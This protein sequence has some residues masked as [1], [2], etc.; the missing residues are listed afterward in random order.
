[1]LRPE[2]APH[3]VPWDTIVHDAK[4][5]D[6]RLT[7]SLRARPSSDTIVV[8]VHG[9]GGCANSR[10]VLRAARACDEAGLS[11]LRVNCR[12]ADRSGEDIYHAG[13]TD[14]LRATLR[15]PELS[16][17]TRIYVVGFSMGGHI[18]I[19][20][21]LEPDRDPRVRAIAAICSPLDLAFGAHDIQRPSGLPYQWHV[22][23]GLK[24]MYVAAG[25]RGHLPGA[26]E[27]VL[28]IRT[29]LEWDEA[30]V[31]PRFG[32]E[33]LS[34][35]YDTAA[36]GPLLHR[37]DLP[38]LFVAA[39]ED[40]V[41]NSAGLRPWLKQASPA[42]EVAWAPRGGHVGFPDDLALDGRDVG[43]LE[44]QLIRWFLKR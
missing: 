39:E 14:D 35:Y 22:L 25:G 9:L 33:S 21:S 15:S 7:G 10:Y 41:V 38:T 27:E 3:D 32:F 17:F 30:V 23:R 42:V 31:V 6:I 2:R 36:A 20:W 34:H 44:P 40:P 13:L 11:Y 16:A 43:P 26:V 8:L 5:G 12:G 4:V 19:R 24:E 1:M 29:I 18:A 28:S 37:V